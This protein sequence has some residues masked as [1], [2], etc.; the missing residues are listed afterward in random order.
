MIRITP[1]LVFKL[2]SL[3]TEMLVVLRSRA[4]TT[5]PGL[6]NTTIVTMEMVMK[7]RIMKRTPMASSTR[8]LALA[9][10]HTKKTPKR[11]QIPNANSK[12]RMGGKEPGSFPKSATDLLNKRQHAGDA[13]SMKK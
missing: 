3:R 1:T 5:N 11:V 8:L 13:A 6:V 2:V 9:P 7:K 10:Q 4:A 12:V